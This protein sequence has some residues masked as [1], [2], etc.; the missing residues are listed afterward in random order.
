MPLAAPG[1]FPGPGEVG[2]A[3]WRTQRAVERAVDARLAPLG[4]SAP[5][6]RVMRLLAHEPAPALSGHSRTYVCFRA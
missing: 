3:V 4:L 1:S 2:A 6:V 5:A